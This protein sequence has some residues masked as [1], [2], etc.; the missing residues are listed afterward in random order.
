MWPVT[1]LDMSNINE[2]NKS[3][4]V[5]FSHFLLSEMRITTPTVCF[6]QNTATSLEI[7]KC[8]F[9]LFY[10]K[11]YNEWLAIVIGLQVKHSL[12]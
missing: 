1:I 8:R 2:V 10:H 9:L 3:T 4:N 6:A 5:C 12:I 7:K 11:N